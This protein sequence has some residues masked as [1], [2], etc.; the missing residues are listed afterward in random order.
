[1]RD[2]GDERLIR[3]EKRVRGKEKE[4]EPEAKVQ[5]GNGAASSNDAQGNI[6]A[7]QG[8]VLGNGGVENGVAENKAIEIEGDQE[9][10]DALDNLGV[11]AETSRWVIGSIEQESEK[12]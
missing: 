5:R 6:H 9:M 10:M 2:T 7:Q 1:M 12:G 8:G 4:E 3:A 11:D